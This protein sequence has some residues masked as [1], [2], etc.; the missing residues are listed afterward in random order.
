MWFDFFVPGQRFYE[1]GN[2]VSQESKA[3]E[4]EDALTALVNL[5]MSH[6]IS[7]C[8]HIVAKL[9][10]ATIIGKAER[11]LT[12]EEIAKEHGGVINVNYLQRI[13]RLLNSKGIFREI[14]VE[15]SIIP[16]FENNSI[17]QLL[18]T[19]I[20][21]QPS[22]RL[23]VI[24]S[25]ESPAWRSW[26]RLE[27]CVMSSEPRVAFVEENGM[28]LFQ[29]ISKNPESAEAFND[30]LSNLSQSF[31]NEIMKAY[32]STLD[33]LEKNEAT[34]IDV[35][36]GHG[37]A[38]KSIKE[39]YPKLNCKVVD[40]ESVVEGAP[41]KNCGIEFVAGDFFKPETLPKADVIFMKYIL[42]DWTDENCKKILESCNLALNEGGRLLLAESVLPNAGESVGSELRGLDMFFMDIQ[43]MVMVGGK[44]RT[45]DEWSKLLEE[46]GHFK[47][48]RI[49]KTSIATHQLIE[50]YK[51]QN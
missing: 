3:K 22:C 15:E 14:R 12:A 43:M 13:L 25:T 5:S 10:V 26:S 45:A 2:K 34:V 48:N 17:S 11:A 41:D 23:S 30:A 39:K 29:Y 19:D 47:I 51:Q 6:V 38:M 20:P 44:E 18:R 42:H 49:I 32:G 33:E 24:H 16:A 9:N 50:A 21:N 37:L 46:D 36:G 31:I 40:L 8:L 27:K 28:A 7:Q 35:G 1:M 4:P